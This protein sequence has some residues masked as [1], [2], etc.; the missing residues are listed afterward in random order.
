MSQRV[1]GTTSVETGPFLLI[2]T[3]VVST[4]YVL[5]RYLRTRANA[6]LLISEVTRHL[7]GQ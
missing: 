4:G 2:A 3:L 1:G 6:E 7:G 5:F